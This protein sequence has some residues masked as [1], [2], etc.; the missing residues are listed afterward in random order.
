MTTPSR[1][2]RLR[3]LEFVMLSAIIAV[4]IGLVVLM[5]TRQLMLALIFFGI[6]FIVSLVGIAMFSLTIKPGDAEKTDLDEQD[7]EDRGH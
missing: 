2:D 5:S 7:H 6:A 1:Q 4:F 3:P